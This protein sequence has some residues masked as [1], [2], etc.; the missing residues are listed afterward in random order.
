MEDKSVIKDA[1]KKNY[2]LYNKG[3]FLNK[4]DNIPL[5]KITPLVAPKLNDPP[6]SKASGKTNKVVPMKTNEPSTSSSIG[7]NTILNI[8]PKKEKC[9]NQK[10]AKQWTTQTH[11]P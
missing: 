7:N 1:T 2:N 11:M 3:T 6:P 8:V 5:R 9:L 10:L 4:D